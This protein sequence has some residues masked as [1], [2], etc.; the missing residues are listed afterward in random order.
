[1]VFK[2]ASKNCSN[3]A[4]EVETKKNR[5]YLRR[6]F[7]INGEQGGIQFFLNTIIFMSG[8]KLLYLHFEVI[9]HILIKI[10]YQN[11]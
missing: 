4:D 10:K 3:T 6:E 8:L 7:Y 1:M 2:K 11:E 5:L 9:G